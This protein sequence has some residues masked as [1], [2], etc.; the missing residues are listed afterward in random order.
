MALELGVL[1]VMLGWPLMLFLADSPLFV[2]QVP[3]SLHRVW[4][5]STAI[6]SS[7]SSP[8]L[9]TVWFK[10]IATLTSVQVLGHIYTWLKSTIVL[11]LGSSPWLLQILVEVIDPPSS[12]RFMSLTL[13]S[14]G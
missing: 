8:L 12:F 11:S 3:N 1:P 13:I 9:F 2:V 5:K 6:C 10:S 7:G 4:F 14:S